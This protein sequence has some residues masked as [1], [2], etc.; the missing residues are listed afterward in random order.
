MWLIILLI[1]ALIAPIFGLIPAVYLFTKRR[2]TLYFITLNGWITGAIVLQIF[3]LISVIVIGWVV[4]L[5]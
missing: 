1:V 5:H 3:Y 2:S 4:S